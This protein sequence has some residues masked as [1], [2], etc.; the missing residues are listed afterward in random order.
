M[1][2]C[3]GIS[4]PENSKEKEIFC[5]SVEKVKKNVLHSAD[6]LHKTKCSAPNLFFSDLRFQTRCLIFAAHCKFF[7]LLSTFVHP[8]T[9]ARHT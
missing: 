7:F 8:S 4:R 2:Y 5:F 6:N 3:N 9:I 1:E